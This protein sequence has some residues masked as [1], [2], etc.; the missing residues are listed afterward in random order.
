MGC[1]VHI[2]HFELMIAYEALKMSNQKLE[3]QFPSFKKYLTV[4]GLFLIH[5][6]FIPA[7]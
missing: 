6:D 7:Y 5:N 2:P 3:V 4:I 1:H